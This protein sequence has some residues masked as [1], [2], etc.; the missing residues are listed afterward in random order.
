MY[1]RSM[2]EKHLFVDGKYAYSTA[3]G[4][5][6]YSRK[7]DKSISVVLLVYLIIFRIIIIISHN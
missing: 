1:V 4:H 3:S 2:Y 6:S 5:I 7:I